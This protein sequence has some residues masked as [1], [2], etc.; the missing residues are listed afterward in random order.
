MAAPIISSAMRHRPASARCSHESLP[1]AR[2]NEGAISCAL[3][4]EDGAFLA[5]E[6]IFLA[7]ATLASS[8]HF[9]LA[10]SMGAILEAEDFNPFPT[11]FLSDRKFVFESVLTPGSSPSDRPRTI[12]GR[13]WTSTMDNHRKRP[14]A[15]HRARPLALGTAP[16]ALVY[17]PRQRGG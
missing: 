8:A 14:T 4:R 15:R 17:R 5:E 11:H 6:S 3:T 10:E 7:G 13:V 12:L 1:V 2:L 16:K 9:L